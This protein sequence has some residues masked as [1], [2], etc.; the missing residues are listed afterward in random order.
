MKYLYPA[1]LVM[2]LAGCANQD[3]GD[4]RKYV[5]EVKARPSTPIEPIPQIKQA[6]TYLYV[7]GNRRNPFVPTEDG[8]EVMVNTDSTGP[9]PDPNRRKEELESFPLDA[10]KMVGTLDQKNSVW[11]LVQSPDGTIHRVKSGNYLGQNDGRIVSIEEEKINVTELIPNGS[12]GY[13][14]RQASL[15][16]GERD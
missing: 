12:G 10:L 1:V 2:L 6:E 7:G 8:T 13:L 9:R 5:E 4:L 11:A 3:M 14:E 15:A 16:L